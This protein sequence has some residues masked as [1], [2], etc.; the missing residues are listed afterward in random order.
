[1]TI[2]N[3]VRSLFNH[4]YLIGQLV[5]REV[6]LRYRGSA[7][8]IGW[9]FLHPLLLLLAFTLVFSGVF[10]DRWDEG[11]ARKSGFE[12]A[13]LIYCGLAVFTPFAEVVTSAP[14]LLLANQN[15]VKKI[16]FPTEILPVVSLIAASIHGATHVVLLALGALLAGQLHSAA[17]LVPLVV[18]PAW[19]M[20]L[21]IAWFLAAAGAYVRDLAHAVPLL[22]QLLMFL[23][24]VFYPSDT[25]PRILQLV[26][27]VNPLALAINDMRRA[28]LYGEPPVWTVWFVMLVLGTACAALGYA[29][30]AR[31]REEFA[32]VL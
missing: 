12:M 23:L 31:C 9:S 21:G 17:L 25:A 22:A 8:G 18:F 24:P 7:L 30:F 16:V 11:G 13:L 4:R 2:L 28:M 27:G 1:M 29:F 5:R 10:S 19:L 6:L 14:R 20:T 32:D 15:F 26:N 3:P